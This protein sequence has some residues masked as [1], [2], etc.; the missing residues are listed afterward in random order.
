MKKTTLI[1]TIVFSFVF[2]A[3]CTQFV[4]SEV[5]SGDNCPENVAYLQSGVDAYYEE[6]GSYPTDFEVLLDEGYIAEI[7]ECPGGNEY[8]IVDGIVIEQ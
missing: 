5:T 2:V 6:N 3:G 4:E 1:F 8:V 7:L